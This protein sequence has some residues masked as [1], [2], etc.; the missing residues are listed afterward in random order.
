MEKKTIGAFISA[1]RKANGLTQRQ[2]AEKL[3]VSDKAVSRWERDEA[4]PDLTLIPVLA[5]IFGVTSDEILRGQR[6]NPEADPIRSP[7]KTDKQRKNILS[8]RATKYKIRSTIVIGIGIIGFIAAMICNFGFLRAYIGFLVGSVFF[9]AAAVCQTI[10]LTLHLSG[11]DEE[12][13]TAEELAEYRR[14]CVK[15][16]CNVYCMIGTLFA[17]TMPLVTLPWDT[18]QG[19]DPS[20]WLVYGLLFGMIGFAVC[21]LICRITKFV[22]VKRGFLTQSSREHAIQTLRLRFT[23]LFALGMAGLL[24]IQAG[25]NAFLPACLQEGTVFTDITSFVAFM[26]TPIEINWVEANSGNTM[27]VDI[28]T[29]IPVESVPTDTENVIHHEDGSVSYFP[30]DPD[31][32]I[33]DPDGNVVCEFNLKNDTVRGWSIDWKEDSPVITVY[34]YEDNRALNTKMEWINRIYILLYPAAAAVIFLLYLKKAK[35]ITK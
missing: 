25:L 8:D 11:M 23:G 18:Y 28:S 5:E 20:A 15:L 33:T 30:D 31:H 24:L 22:L 3:N 19:I 21:F 32:S 6:H 34:T 10:F 9:V 14:S 4:M 27:N 12:L 13:L 17:T 29:S 26:E 1:L 2:L 7:E 35:N 16:S